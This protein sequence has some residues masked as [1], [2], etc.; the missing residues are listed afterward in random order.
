[1][2]NILNEGFLMQKLLLFT[3][4]TANIFVSTVQ[5]V[6]YI[7]DVHYV[8]DTMSEDLKNR[9]A[10]IRNSAISAYNLTALIA[11]CE[12]DKNAKADITGANYTDQVGMSDVEK[13]RCR[14]VLKCPCVANYMLMTLDNYP[15]KNKAVPEDTKQRLEESWINIMQQGDMTFQ[16][17]R[18]S[19]VEPTGAST[20]EVSPTSK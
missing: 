2:F 16:D 11:R 7:K 19:H 12:K 8:V 18:N 4:F 1:M 14:V 9:D 10:R 5:A 6:S 17:I 3:M 13:N 20:S 15:Y